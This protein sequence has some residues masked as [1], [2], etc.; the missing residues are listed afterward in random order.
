MIINILMIKRC[1]LIIFVAVL[2]LSVISAGYVDPSEVSVG[3]GDEMC[4]GVDNNDNSFIDEGLIR[5]CSM[6]N[7]NSSL[8]DC[9][10]IKACTW[11]GWFP[12]GNTC[13]IFDLLLISE[14]C[15]GLDD[16]CNGR[17]DESFDI[18]QDCGLCGKI[19]CND[20][21]TRG[22]CAGEGVCSNGATEVRSC[23]FND[24]GECRYGSG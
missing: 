22:I 18:G 12:E 5:D 7:P 24:V 11:G 1:V 13:N 4:D 17:V 20:I 2:F 19:S 9:V 16:N 23:G 8:P 14:T 21:G 10:G 6:S 15:N 3:V